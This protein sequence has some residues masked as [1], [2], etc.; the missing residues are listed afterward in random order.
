MSFRRAQG[1][2]RRVAASKGRS[3]T[4]LAVTVYAV[5]AV[6]LAVIDGLSNISM[7]RSNLRFADGR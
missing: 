7:P 4:A 2:S 1:F 3:A 6:I 5:L